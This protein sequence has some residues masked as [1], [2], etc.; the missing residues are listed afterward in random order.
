[1]AKD[2]TQTENLKP[3]NPKNRSTNFCA[4]VAAAA[5]VGCG[6]GRGNSRDASANVDAAV[7]PLSAD[8]DVTYKPNALAQ[9]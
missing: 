6:S 2:K 7:K 9:G 4:C 5:D 8:L 3:K 1:M